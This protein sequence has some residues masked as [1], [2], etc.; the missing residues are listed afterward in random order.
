MLGVYLSGTGNTKHCIEKLT[1]L[2]DADAQTVP[3]EAPGVMEQIK[4]NDIILFGYPIQFSNAPCMVR[5]FIRKNDKVWEKK[6]I[7]CVATMGAFSAFWTKT[8]VLQKD[9][10][11]Y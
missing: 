6:K 8:L 10:R 3:L 11:L 5:D 7:L 9:G 1:G 2:L 4:N